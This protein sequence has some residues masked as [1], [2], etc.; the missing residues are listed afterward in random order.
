[1]APPDMEEPLSF[2]LGSAEVEED[3]VGGAVTVTTCPSLVWTDTLALVVVD[4][5]VVFCKSKV[6][7]KVLQ[8]YNALYND[9]LDKSGMWWTQR[10]DCKTSI[11]EMAMTTNTQR[12]ESPSR[13]SIVLLKK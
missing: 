3:S 9:K 2:E 8:K 1:M 10:A 4:G 7:W 11:T 5:S 12:K 13:K 6:S